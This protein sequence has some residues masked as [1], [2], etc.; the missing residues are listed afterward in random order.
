MLPFT[1]AIYFSKRPPMPSTTF[2]AVYQVFFGRFL[3]VK[4]RFCVPRDQDSILCQGIRICLFHSEHQTTRKHRKGRPSF[5]SLHDPPS[6][7]G[8]F[9][10]AGG[11]SAPMD[12]AHLQLM[13]TSP[14]ISLGFSFEDAHCPDGQRSKG[15][16][17]MGN[18]CD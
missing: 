3:D 10:A 13:L 1:R 12:Q 2:P 17:C 6:R 18:R 15:V 9:Q 7:K 16:I 8:S 4:A 5:C 14:K 11:G